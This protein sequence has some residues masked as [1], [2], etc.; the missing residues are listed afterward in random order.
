[1]TAF[2]V[3]RLFEIQVI[4][5]SEYESV[6]DR[7]LSRPVRY[8][9]APRG[10]ILDRTGTPLLRDEP[11]WDVT[12][13]Y[14]VLSGDPEYLLKQAARQIRSRGR[15]P[16]G[17]TLRQIADDCKLEIA[18]MWQRLSEISGQPISDF[19]ERSH[20]IQARV[21][22]I[23]D[24]VINRSGST[25][26]RVAE[27]NAF[28][29]V[30]EGVSDE[31]AL[32]IRFEM[33][34]KHPWLS[35]V[36][37]A[38]RRLQDADA[39]IHLLGRMGQAS[40]A[41]LE[42][43]PLFDDEL[44]ALRPGDLC[45][46]SGVEFT[47]DTALRGTRGRVTEDFERKELDRVEPIA[48]RSVRLNLDIELQRRAYEL[49]G[50]AVDA[51]EFPCG[52]SA[53]VLDARTREV[54]A[55]VSYPTYSA[56]DLRERYKGLLND[57]RWEPL[58]FR[59]VA[60]EYP[61]GSPCKAATLIGAISD[62]LVKPETRIR[63]TG[64]L[65][66]NQ[67][68]VFRCW[69][70]NKYPGTT[71]DIRGFPAG[72]TAEDAIQCSCNIYFFK[73]GEQLGAGRLC[74]W[75]A[76]LGL[77]QLQ[78]TGLIEEST[79]IVPTEEFLRHTQNRGYQPSDAWNYSIGQ[80][81]V[82]ATPLQAANIAATIATG[83]LAPARL[84][85]VEHD[86]LVTGRSTLAPVEFDETALRVMRSGM[87]RVVNET[88]GTADVAKLR[89]TGYSMC[90]KTGSAQATQR[91]LTRTIT[92]EWPDGRR[93]EI[94]A[95]NEPDAREMLRARHPEAASLGADIR[96]VGSHSLTRYPPMGPE[97][98]L[99]SHAWFIGFSQAADT[100]RG[101]APRG[102]VLA[103]SV[104]IEYGGSGGHAAGPVARDIMEAAIERVSTVDGIRISDQQ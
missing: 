87:W 98:K 53:V 68:G 21:G 70:Y 25:W 9:S 39:A 49:L 47:A 48:G 2:I 65:L 84:F 55:L 100:P 60:G 56:D 35:V 16:A 34:G 28:H 61:P 42:S 11:A 82:T 79:G 30:L 103:I 64:H 18:Q 89:M 22:R 54:L 88:G 5:A 71:H 4:R 62:G 69:I 67:P 74:D 24:S 86:G 93:E 90:G 81:E 66:P 36:P 94:V 104:L 101:A 78:G 63:C 20:Q 97:D 85:G 59:A 23:R 46:V 29:P 37:G 96:V 102:R 14:G 76:R 41:R 38:R 17:S 50:S 75:F 12:I 45:G 51:G 80:G 95:I 83:E 10:E 52:G 43:D 27:E 15:A 72:L 57:A 19:I 40:T 73:A 13:H 6:S 7:L 8:L 32:A 58:R 1:M 77:G 33:E 31:Q 26:T 44:R 99:P 3:A 92:F 91:V